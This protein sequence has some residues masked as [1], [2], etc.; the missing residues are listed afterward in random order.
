ML[1]LDGYDH[2]ITLIC[3]CPGFESLQDCA[4][5][6]NKRLSFANDT[7]REAWLRVFQDKQCGVSCDRA[8]ECYGDVPACREKRTGCECCS[9]NDDKLT[10][11]TGTC[12][13]CRTCSEVARD[14]GSGNVCVTG[15]ALLGELRRCAC[16][17]CPDECTK[18]C[19]GT[20]H[21]SN[22]GS[23]ACSKCLGGACQPAL[24]ACL[25]DAP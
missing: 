20:G 6:A 2:A 17:A 21:L 13:S 19:Q 14:S 15:N 18:V 7:E 22:N 4:G 3:Q 9:W 10:C 24:A 16:E 23:D 8:D 12:E 5:S 11:T 1:E 25:A